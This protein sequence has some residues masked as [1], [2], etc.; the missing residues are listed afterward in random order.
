MVVSDSFVFVAAPARHR[1][2]EV[3][4]VLIP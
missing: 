4:P 3:N 2:I 1:L